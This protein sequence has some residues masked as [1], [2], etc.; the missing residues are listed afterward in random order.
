M[1]TTWGKCT[2]FSTL[3]KKKFPLFFQKK[4]FSS[5]LHFSQEKVVFLVVVVEEESGEGERESDM[6]KVKVVQ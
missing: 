5:H 3:Y 6:E 1:G 2:A 4:N